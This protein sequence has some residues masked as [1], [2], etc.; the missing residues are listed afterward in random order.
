MQDNRRSSERS[1]T[2]SQ[3][4][5]ETWTVDQC[6][7]YTQTAERFGFVTSALPDPHAITSIG[8]L[9][10]VWWNGWWNWSQWFPRW[11]QW[12]PQLCFSFKLFKS[13]QFNTANRP[14]TDPNCYINN[15]LGE[16]SLIAVS[17]VDNAPEEITA[18]RADDKEWRLT[19]S[20][21]G[22]PWYPRNIIITQ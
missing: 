9:L 13:I 22:L 18:A 14:S 8:L 16:Q 6:I 19:L 15:H 3:R 17:V 7:C 1:R 4:W 2:K 5:Y 12:P 11:W 21:R 10:L 20:Y